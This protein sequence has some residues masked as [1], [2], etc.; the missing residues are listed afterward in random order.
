MEVLT[1][2]GCP[3]KADGGGLERLALDYLGKTRQYHGV[4]YRGLQRDRACPN[5]IYPSL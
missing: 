1:L 2:H 3:V 5:D 4:V